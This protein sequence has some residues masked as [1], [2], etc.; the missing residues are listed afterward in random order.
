MRALRL[1]LS[2]VLLLFCCAPALAQ[3]ERILSYDSDITVND[4]G[5]MLVTESIRVH[6]AGD[7]IKHGIY[8]DFPT[9]YKNK[10]GIRTHV[11]FEIVRVT[12]EGQP[13]DYHTSS[14][15]NG[16]RVYLGPRFSSI[17]PG[18]YTYAITYRTDRQLGYYDDRDEIYWN[19]TGNGWKFPIERATATVHLPSRI[20]RRVIETYGYT[21]PQG[22]QGR[23]F[24]ASLQLDDSYRFEATRPLAPYEGMT[25]VCW[26][27]KGY[28]HPPTDAQNRAWFLQDN[29]GIVFAVAGLVIVLLYQFV[30]WSKVGKDPAPGTIVPQYMPPP[31]LSAPAVR[32][33]VKM[34]FD[35]KAF[36]ACLV[37]MASKKFLTIEK[38]AL[39]AYALTANKDPKYRALLSEEERLVADRLFSTRDRLLLSPTNH[40]PISE[41]ISALKKALSLKMERVYFVGNSKYLLPSAALSILTLLAAVWFSDSGMKPVALFMIVWLAFW[42]VGVAA[43]TMQVIN[44]WKAALR[45]GPGVAL[46]FGGALFLTLFALP[47]LAG[48]VFGI[49]ALG[50]ATSVITVFVFGALVASNFVYHELLKAPTRLGRDFLDKIEGFKMFLA[51]TEGD[52][53]KRMAPVNWNADTFNRFLPYA[54]ALDVEA[55]WT[56]K[57]N[58]AVTAAGAAAATSSAAYSGA[59][60]ATAIGSGFATSLGDS[61]T[62]AISSS[63]SAPGSGSGAGGGGS[64]GGGGGGGGGGGW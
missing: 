56:A 36:A 45:G 15:S 51:S 43:L 42:T 52:Q 27:E 2:S 25:I 44:L 54:I 55:E 38:D 24:K 40:A 11:P 3:Q 57:F 21:G 30:T 37:A 28:M 47:F 58:Q 5:S 31:E 20:P 61:L 49:F 19:V 4:D 13:E 35:N 9:E 60:A 17:P 39:D 59:L 16:V 26:W 12:R 50:S 63:S 1:L 29:Q 32:E 64:S 41:A 48:E 8:R 10:L 14:Q 34:D 33:L 62:S 18:D 53:I 6:A 23:D 46:K 22:Y 7:Q